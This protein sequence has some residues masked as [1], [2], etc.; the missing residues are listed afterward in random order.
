MIDDALF[1]MTHQSE[2]AL[3]TSSA[4]SNGKQNRLKERK[5]PTPNE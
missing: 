3:A 4:M 2:E 5:K 1:V